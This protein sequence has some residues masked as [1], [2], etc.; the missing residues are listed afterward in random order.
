MGTWFWLNIPLALLFVCCWAGIPMWLLHT[1]WHAEV[2]AKHAEVKAKHASTPNSRHER[3]LSQSWLSQLRLRRLTKPQ[4]P[5]CSPDRTPCVS[6]SALDMGQPPGA[7]LVRATGG[8]RRARATRPDVL[9]GGAAAMTGG[10]AR[11]E[12]Q[13]GIP[14]SESGRNPGKSGSSP[15]TGRGACPSAVIET[16]PLADVRSYPETVN[17]VKGRDWP[18]SVSR[19]PHC[20]GCGRW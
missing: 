8:N 5:P 20:T 18:A 7:E 2:E 11:L 9:A 3:S 14:P 17:P 15:Q 6:A 1:R 19:R 4:R 13:R 16:G 10:S 12:N